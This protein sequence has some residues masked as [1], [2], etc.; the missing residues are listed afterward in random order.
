[1]PSNTPIYSTTNT[2]PP[3]RLITPPPPPRLITGLESIVSLMI[4]LFGLV[5]PL[6]W[7]ADRFAL[8]TNMQFYNLL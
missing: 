1:M 8:W 7:I 3:P 2:P 4:V 5:G 6:Y